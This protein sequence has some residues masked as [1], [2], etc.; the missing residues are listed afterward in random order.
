MTR[1]L[2]V[3]DDPH[4]RDLLKRLLGPLG[5]VVTAADPKGA[6]ARLAEEGPF[7][8][9]LTDMAMPNAR[10]GLEVL[11]AVRARGPDTPVIVVTAFG[12]IEG[13]LDSIQQGAFDYLAKP[14][15]VDAILRVSRRAVEQ[16]RLGE[17][18]RSLR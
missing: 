9:V 5:E 15:D 3:D 1:L 14:F 8:L 6:S 2:V 16:K 18:Y 17:E 7:D 13:A 11:Q 4:A 12:N 10:D